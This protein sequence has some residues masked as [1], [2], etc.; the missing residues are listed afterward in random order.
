MTILESVVE[1][2][3][4]HKIGD[5]AGRE[6]VALAMLE[7]VGLVHR[8]CGAKP[9]PSREASSSEPRSRAPWSPA[10]TW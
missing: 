6:Q 2:L 9:T 10:P 5:P 4:I 7:R 8:L 1:P 3:H